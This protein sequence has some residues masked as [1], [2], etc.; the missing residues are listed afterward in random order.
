MLFCDLILIYLNSKL[1]FIYFFVL[2]MFVQM[3]WIFSLKTT[4]ISWR[5]LFRLFLHKKASSEPSTGNV[6]TSSS[7]VCVIKP[8][9]IVSLN[10]NRIAYSMGRFAKI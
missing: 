4:N 10:L 2:S 9:N 3:N 6:A 7:D 1:K 8:K 5:R